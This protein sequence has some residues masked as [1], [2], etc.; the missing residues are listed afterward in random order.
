[1]GRICAAGW[2]LVLCLLQL[3]ALP[4]AIAQTTLGPRDGELEALLDIG[5]QGQ[6]SADHWTPLWIVVPP[7]P[8][9][10]SGIA[11]IETGPRGGSASM[12]ASTP[13][14]TTPGQQTSTETA[15]LVPPDPDGWWMRL[16]IRDERDQVRRSLR[17]ST[18]ASDRTAVHAMTPNGAAS[19]QIVLSG[20]RTSLADLR[21]TGID[22][23]RLEAQQGAG[24]LISS[25]SIAEIPAQRLPTRWLAYDGVDVLVLEG[26]S[27]LSARP[28]S[29]A[30]IRDWVRAGGR[31]VVVA[32]RPGL[33]LEPLVPEGF[34]EVASRPVQSL[35]GATGE[36]TL[37]TPLLSGAARGAGWSTRTVFADGRDEEAEGAAARSADGTILAQVAE[38]PVGY[39]WVSVLGSDPGRA[40]TDLVLKR[41]WA[42]VL[43]P[44]L[45]EGPAPPDTRGWGSRLD[46]RTLVTSRALDGLVAG[47]EVQPRLRVW[48]FVVFGLLLALIVGPVDRFALKRL[49]ALQ[50]SW[51]TAL[52][53]IGVFSAVAIL[54]PYI[55]RSA[56]AVG[57]RATVTDVAPTDGIVARSTVTAILADRSRR[58]PLETNDVG[59]WHRSIASTGNWWSVEVDPIDVLVERAAQ[60]TEVRLRIWSLFSFG[61]ET[62]VLDPA[63]VPIDGALTRDAEGLRVEIRGVDAADV[64][65]QAGLVTDAGW[66]DLALAPA[67]DALVGRPGLAT[68]SRPDGWGRDQAEYN[69][70]SRSDSALAAGNMLDVHG[71]DRRSEMQRAIVGTGRWG[72]VEL[73]LD[74]GGGDTIADLPIEVDF[75]VV[76]LLLPMPD[77]ESAR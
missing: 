61:G 47:S 77:E 29:L 19:P 52:A 22:R 21:A 4:H 1:M 74:R 30:A 31:L 15:I 17:Y 68:R 7:T 69:P 70:W 28:A 33:P 50:H 38:G 65:G 27:L 59:T 11:T 57:L 64:V 44:L 75:E 16:T 66:Q 63:E 43:R 60:A 49:R 54:F 6:T 58:A 14:V 46:A 36:R 26:R 45:G 56:T 42:A 20:R 48:P 12:R 32:G 35:D 51:L 3:A 9:G 62:L 40:R 25:L 71:A 76:R 23:L 24:G 10:I 37:P 18:D 13:I 55:I 67:G 2:L 41:E 72:V 53:W 5:W 73:A 8:E 39:G 34:V